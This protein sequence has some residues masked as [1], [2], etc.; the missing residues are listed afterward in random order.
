MSSMW[1]FLSNKNGTWVEIKY[2]VNKVDKKYIVRKLQRDLP[3]WRNVLIF[4]RQIKPKQWGHFRGYKQ[5]TGV[6][7]IPSQRLLS[8]QRK[9]T[10]G[11]LT[12]Y[13]LWR[14]GLLNE[15]SLY[16]SLR[17]GE[18]LSHQI[19]WIHIFI[20]VGFFSNNTIPI[21]V[22]LTIWPMSHHPEVKE[23]ECK[24]HSF[25]CDT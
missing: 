13:F 11:L 20:I 21:S 4:Q 24:K 15:T 22:G 5:E 8:F 25:Y 14:L 2:W 18:L 1:R 12:C 10:K 7:P 23:M 19:L 16:P 17:N 9:R 3:L 6:L